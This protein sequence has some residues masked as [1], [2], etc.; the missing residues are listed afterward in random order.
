MVIFPFPQFKQY[1]KDMKNL[2]VVKDV[3]DKRY[4]VTIPMD[5]LFV[6]GILRVPHNPRGIV[7]FA[8]GSGSGR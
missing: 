3:H 6:E 8:H 5:G 1:A 2:D 7:L 4:T